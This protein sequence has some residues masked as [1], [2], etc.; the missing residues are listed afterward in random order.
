[1]GFVR[2]KGSCTMWKAITGLTQYAPDQD[3]STISIST[4]LLQVALKYDCR[5][6]ITFAPILI[7]KLDENNSLGARANRGS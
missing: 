4:P 1:M 6:T 2:Q 3:T 7:P 5:L